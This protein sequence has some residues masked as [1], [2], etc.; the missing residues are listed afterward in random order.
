MVANVVAKSVRKVLSAEQADRYEKELNERWEATK[1]M[2]ATGF[3]AKMDELLHLTAEQRE[4]LTKILNAQWKYSATRARLL[5]LG[6][7][8]FP[9]M[10]ETEIAQ[11]L[12][13]PQK[14]VWA[15]VGQK[16]IVNFGISLQNQMQP[17]IEE[18][19][20]EPGQKP[21]SKDSN[22]ASKTK[23]LTRRNADDRAF[24]SADDFRPSRFSSPLDKG[25]QGGSDATS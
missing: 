12:T 9:A 1:Q 23:G 22:P 14:R 18:V 8:Y 11:I 15:G 7:Q 5:T 6:N 4:K 17:D 20:D 2:V 21:A 24:S 25:G 16:G 10:P 3:V 13:E 19:W